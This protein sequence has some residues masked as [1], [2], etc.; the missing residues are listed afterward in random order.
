MSDLCN[1]LREEKVGNAYANKF[2]SCEIRNIFFPQ[3]F[4]PYQA[5]YFPLIFMI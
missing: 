3:Q 1:L 4:L 2:K 5:L